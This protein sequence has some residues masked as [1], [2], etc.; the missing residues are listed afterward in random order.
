L[1]E[2]GYLKNS[3]FNSFG[4]HKPAVTIFIFDLRKSTGQFDWKIHESNILSKIKDHGD[5]W[6]INNSIPSKY[7]IIIMFPLIEGLN[8]E[9]CRNSFKKAMQL[10]GDEF[11]KSS[12]S[13][14]YFL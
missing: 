5:K 13:S 10:S 4:F 6:Q 2:I 9:E 3:F 7:M 12:N 1:G 8:V 14:N 11:I